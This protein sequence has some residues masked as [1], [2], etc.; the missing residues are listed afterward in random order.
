ML[1]HIPNVL[2]SAEL[3]ECREKLAGA[4]WADGRSTAGHQSVKVKDNLQLPQDCAEARDLGTL[5]LCALERNALF[6]SAALPRFVYPPLFNKYEN[7]MSFGS[8]ID[9]AI[10]AVP[11]SARRIRTDVSATLFLSA[12]QDY[13]GGELTAEDTF[14]TR[15]VKLPAGDMVLYPSTSLHRVEKVTRGARVAAFFWVQSVVKDDAERR[16]LFDLD[17]AVVS[18]GGDMPD[19]PALTLLTGIY[20]NLVRKWGEV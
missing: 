8:H 7:G 1:L 10:R 12:P 19:H 13:D 15:G 9:N 6:A 14:G 11:D 5:V 16:M 2:T 20:H 18:V 4:P 17:R 3:A